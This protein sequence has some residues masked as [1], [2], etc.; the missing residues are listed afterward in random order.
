[1]Q[2]RSCLLFW[3]NGETLSN[4][5]VALIYK[6]PWFGLASMQECLFTVE[7]GSD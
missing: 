7:V 3:V 2:V 4:L 1:M 5:K 6:D